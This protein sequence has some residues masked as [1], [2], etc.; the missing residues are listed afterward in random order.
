MIGHMWQVFAY[1]LRRNLRRRGFLFTTFGIPLIVFVIYFGYRVITEINSGNNQEPTP[2]ATE[3]QL[4][5]AFK[6]V[7]KAGYVDL[8]GLFPDPGDLGEK[9]IRIDSE[10]TAQTV[11]A[12]GGV[13]VYFVIQP[14]YAET[15]D[16]TLVM[17][18][19]NLGQ[20]NDD[21]IQRL[22]LNQLAKDMDAN[23]FNRLLDPAMFREVNLQRDA[24]GQKATN[25]GIDSGVVYI[26][27]ITFML[28]VFTTNGYLM[29]S[30]IEEKETRLIEILVSSIRPTSLLAGKILAL[31]LLGLIQVVV[32]LGAMFLLARIAA[33]D[34]L[35]SLSFLVNLSISPGQLV[36]FLLYFVLGY[37]SFAAAFGAVGAISN[38][39]QEGP[40]LS[41]IFTLPAIAPYMLIPVFVTQPDAALPVIMSLLPIT[42]PLAMII[43]SSLTTIPLWQL[44]LS[45]VLLVAFDVFMIWMAGRIFRFQ[46]LLAGK[47]PKLR[48]LPRLV[49]G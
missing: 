8:S 25:T 33:G 46:S 14:D 19:F 29:Q 10:D 9:L 45:L 37:L 2:S 20:A 24:S 16:V 12:A 7:D 36:L 15:G 6:T 4:A 49:R 3:Q 48:D 18:R 43:R 17:P 23:L 35:A 47:A 5:D 42:S 44:G 22:V 27:V 34:A 30:V 11:L 41:A 13:D 31:G 1:E 39:M 38:S 32:W 40:Q 28:A 26:F 21:P